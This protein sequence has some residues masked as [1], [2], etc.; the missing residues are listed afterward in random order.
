MLGEREPPTRGGA[1]AGRGFEGRPRAEGKAPLR[2]TGLG[3]DR[4]T[5]LGAPGNSGLGR[6]DGMRLRSKAEGG[7]PRL[8]GELLLLLRPC[9]WEGGPW[10]SRDV[11]GRGPLKF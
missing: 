8:P 5:G 4:G 2:S 11:F 7:G 9:W 6:P 1:G 10:R 3:P